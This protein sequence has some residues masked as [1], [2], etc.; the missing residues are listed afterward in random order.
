MSAIEAT[1]EV[2]VTA[3]K[4]LKPRQREAVLERMLAEEGISTDIADTLEL[5]ARRRQPRQPFRQV[6]K[7]L[8]IKA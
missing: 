3:F 8:G 4:S 6:M 2:F 1:A 5:E 7:D